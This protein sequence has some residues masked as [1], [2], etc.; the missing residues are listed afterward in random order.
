[1]ATIIRENSDNGPLT[2]VIVL[3]IAA[4]CAIGAYFFFNSDGFNAGGGDTINI[5][6][7]APV[8]PATN[9]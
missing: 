6:S 9:P 8:A 7:P 1:M 5:E 2:A 3:L 4:A